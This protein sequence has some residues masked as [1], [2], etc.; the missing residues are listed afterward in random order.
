[1]TNVGRVYILNE[2]YACYVLCTYFH[3][4]SYVCIFEYV[5]T[6]AVYIAM[7]FLFI[8]A[9]MLVQLCFLRAHLVYVCVYEKPNCVT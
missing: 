4:H 5:C 8:C 1:M 9:S 3:V 7:Y 6:W 2:M